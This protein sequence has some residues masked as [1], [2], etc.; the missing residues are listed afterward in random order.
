[1]N[2]AQQLGTFVADGVG[3]ERGAR[4]HGDGRHHLQQMILDHVAQRPGFLIISAAAFHADRFG[5]R[6]LHVIDV[7]AVPERFE[8]AVAEAEGEDILDGFLTEVVIDAVDLAFVE[9]LLQPVRSARRALVR[10]WPKGFSMMIRRQPFS[11]FAIPAPP[12]PSA[13][14][15][16]WLGCVER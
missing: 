5:G 6:D 12:I 8:N 1:M 11:S 2:R 15:A 3:G 10:S 14:G 16:Y 7:A 13:I 9:D 4:L